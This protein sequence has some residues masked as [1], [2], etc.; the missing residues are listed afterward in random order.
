VSDRRRRNRHISRSR[1]GVK[2]RRQICRERLQKESS[3]TEG[4]STRF[5]DNE[6]NSVCGVGDGGDKC[7]GLDPKCSIGELE[8]K[9]KEKKIQ[10]Q[11]TLNTN[12]QHQGGTAFGEAEKEV[13][14]RWRGSQ[15][16]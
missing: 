16:R 12:I 1:L 5:I 7:N 14:R 8:R 2:E 4:G 6:G 10:I 13:V 3:K 15:P 11:T 9:K